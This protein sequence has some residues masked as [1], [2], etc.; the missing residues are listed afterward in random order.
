MNLYDETWDMRQPRCMVRHHQYKACVHKN[1]VV[2]TF[3]H[4]INRAVTRTYTWMYTTA[5]YTHTYHH[6]VLHLWTWTHVDTVL[7]CF[8]PGP[9]V[10]CF[11]W[12]GNLVS[13]WD[14]PSRRWRYC[15]HEQACSPINQPF[16]S[17][18]ICIRK[19]T[20]FLILF[21]WWLPN[22]SDP[23]TG[24]FL[25]SPFFLVRSC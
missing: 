22:V 2:V 5:Y 10:K 19:V 20:W 1:A 14:H 3:L 8:A 15:H 17:G 16:G 4:Q 24:L 11:S 13:I 21:C 6:I 12:I 25:K 9:H 7:I 23:N 18:S